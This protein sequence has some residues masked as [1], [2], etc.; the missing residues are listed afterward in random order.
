MLLDQKVAI[1]YGA[2][3]SVGGAVARAF[4]REG[5]RVVLAGRGLERL[6][7]LADVIRV[8]GGVA[9]A[10]AVDAL[11]EPAVTAAVDGVVAHHGRL[12]I[13]FNLIGLGDV[14]RPLLELSAEDFL[15][16]IVTAMRA[17]LITTRA[18]AR[19]M[20][21]QGAG[22][23]LQFGGGGPQ[24]PPGLGGFKIALDAL[25]SLRRQWA[26]EL[27]PTASAWSR[28]RP[29]GSPRASRPTSRTPRR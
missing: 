14:Q 23:I 11:D 5:A 29:A 18:A 6:E 8:D 12:D 21:R 3:G 7:P 25:E 27:G 16:P 20:A 19:H 22:V 26:V 9:E 28:S 13:S 10:L 15:R 4:A 2:G 17:H 24:T 1:I